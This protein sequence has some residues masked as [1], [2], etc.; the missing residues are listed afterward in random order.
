MEPESKEPQVTDPEV[1]PRV[2]RVQY[3]DEI[4]N[5]HSRSRGRRLS[6]DSIRSMHSMRIVEPKVVLPT[7]FKTLSF[8]VEES[9]TRDAKEALR[10]K[11][12]SKSKDE[13]GVEFADTVWH[14]LDEDELYQRL[15]TSP[16]QGLAKEQVARK[17]K[18]Y[19]PNVFSSPPS[20]WAKKTFL[21]LFGGFGSILFVASIL[22]FIAWKPLGK[23]PQVANLALAVVLA[24]V[25][26]I[27]ACFSFYQ[28]WSSSRVM[29]S[30]TSMIPD[31][32]IVL[33][34]GQQIRIAGSEIVPGDIIYLRLGNKLPA[35]VRYVHVSA[36]A[37]F[38]RSVLTGE[39]VPIRGSTVST[40]DNFLETA[41][42]GMAG[43][44]CVSGEAT[45]VVVATGDNSVFGRLAKLTSAPNTGLTNL[46]R[47]IY[48]F[49]SVI[50]G[51]M[52]TMVIVVITVWATWLR[53]DHPNWL[54]VSNLII[55]CVSVA[56]AFIPEGLPIAV[57]SSLT[58][59]A[60]IMKRNQILCKSLKTVETLG[61][62][63]VIC[64]DK[65]GTLTRNSMTVTDI[66]VE[67]QSL[68]AV[69]AS[70]VMETNGTA[71]PVSAPVLTLSCLSLIGALCNAGEF[72][73]AT[74]SEPLACRKVFGD[75]TDQAVLRFA[76]SLRS[77]AEARSQWASVHR[78]AFNSKNKFMAQLVRSSGIHDASSTNS[79]VL[80]T[81]KGAPD[82]L[83]PRCT[84]YLTSAGIN[85]A[86]DS[87]YSTYLEQTKDRWSREAKRV[88]IFAQKEIP[89][90]KMPAPDSYEFEDWIMEQA[91]SSLGIV[92][93][94]AIT[95]P[96]RQE[97]P[98]VI[99]TLRG[100][101]IKFHMVTG[102]FRLTAQA[103]AENCGIITAHSVDDISALS[104]STSVP[105]TAVSSYGGVDMNPQNP[106]AIVLSGPDMMQLDEDQWENLCA[107]DEIVFARTTPEQKLRIVKEFQ[108]RKETVG[109]TG[110][111][112]NDAPSL[113]AADIG[114]AMGGG[115]EVAIEAA[116][117]VLLDSFAAIVEAVKYG[118]VVFDNLKKTICYLLPAGSFSEFWPIM[119]NVLFGLPQILSSFL[120]IIICCFTD[121]AAAIAIAYEKPEADVLLR[122]P[123][124]PAKD[125]LVNFKLIGYAYG[126]I[127]VLQTVSSFAMSYW[128]ASRRGITFGTLWFGFGTV[129]SNMSM[130]EYTSILN[131]AS[132]IYFVTLVVM[133]WFNLMAVRTRRLSILQH[134]PLFR[135]DTRNVYLFP[136]IVFALLIAVFFNYVPTFQQNLS[137]S[138][139]PV[140][141][142]F[143]PMAFGMAILL[144]DEGRKFWLRKYPHSIIARL[145]W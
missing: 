56:V 120:M 100:A 115:S 44:H 123:R 12:A 114:I 143:L 59:T 144:L 3:A 60:N 92:G 35:D 140:A 49:V 32:A 31:E 82:V 14:R 50:V 41:C 119:T 11:K 26:V 76:E 110:D 89:T 70:G 29:A 98:D 129:P 77:V 104:R 38:D 125:R 91:A 101:G 54:S 73:A 95:D 16:L 72:D 53:K 10:S 118:R 17:L 103:I 145:A 105:S 106:R 133:Q 84:H 81:L 15:S 45:G 20:Q 137:T 66:M 75:A 19:G 4:D 55:A 5:R 135:V 27:Q 141:H 30:I 64:S 88:I 86:I 28:D 85:E 139:I 68:T 113:K 67:Q 127:G 23:P 132:S 65:T 74:V 7:Q 126:F 51:V 87:V 25:W 97:I 112:V 2:L 62:V 107:Y 47:E 42:I 93:L 52:L 128:F 22:V 24:I 13:K 80:L 124:N 71:K 8:N 142:W 102:D 109:M 121:C 94:V 1:Q 63:S 111:G 46:E 9:N 34:D 134:P 57:T 40:D 39:T 78:V 6:M 122:K 61:S 48:Y 99:R 116:D 37:K 36:D 136:A 117:M 43:T 130:A 96:V 21:Y 90:E 131:T 79:T 33:R 108:K 83:L 58:I 69:A 18:D 138:T